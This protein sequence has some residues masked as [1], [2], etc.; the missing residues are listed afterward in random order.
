MFRRASEEDA[1]GRATPVEILVQFVQIGD[2][3]VA[4]RQQ[5]PVRLFGGGFAVGLRAFDGFVDEREVV[6]NQ[7]LLQFADQ[8][9]ECFGG[10]RLKVQQIVNQSVKNRITK[11]YCNY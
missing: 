6:Q 1:V 4:K 11:Q 2:E 5:F 10:T 9:A 7:K 8:L 3:L